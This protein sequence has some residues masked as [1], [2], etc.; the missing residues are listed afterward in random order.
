MKA[1]NISVGIL[2]FLLISAPVV[3]QR[4]ENESLNI[5][6]DPDE[7][8]ILLSETEIFQDLITLTP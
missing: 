3:A 2:F 5:P 8:P 4:I 7:L 1:C 6:L